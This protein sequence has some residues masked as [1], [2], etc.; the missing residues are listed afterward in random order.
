VNYYSILGVPPT[1]ST[2]EIRAA[3]RKLALECHPDRNP[4]NKEAEERFKSISAAYDI[5]SDSD[6]RRQYDTFGESASPAAAATRA[7]GSSNLDDIF[8][9][10]GQVF[11]ASSPFANRTTSKKTPKKKGAANAKTCTKCKGEGMIG[12]DLGFFMFRIACPTCLGTGK[13]I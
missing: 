4:G 7:Y 6:K 5:L 9:M 13:A 10:M 11:G 2:D 1:A 12:A 3:Y 8:E